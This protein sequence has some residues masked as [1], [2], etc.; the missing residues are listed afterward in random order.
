MLGLVWH[1]KWGCSRIIAIQVILL[2]LGMLGL[3]L[4]GLAVDFLRH[5]VTGGAAKPPRWPF[6]WTPPPDWS[7]MTTL[8][9]IALAILAFAATR[10]VL[11][12]LYTIAVNRLLQGEIVVQL[13]SRVYQKMQKLSF[14]FFDANASGAIINRV[15][16]D[17]QAVRSFVDGVTV[18]TLILLLS[19]TVYTVYMVNIDLR[20][21]LA[22]LATTPLMW[23][24]TA[25]FS[26]KVRPA[27]M[28]NRTLFDSLILALSENI[29]GVHVVKGFARQ[30]EEIDKFCDASN[31]V[32]SQKHWIFRQISFFQPLTGFLTQINL[33]VLLAY[34]GLLV[35]RHESAPD[36]ETAAAV[37]L[38]VG[39]L[40]VFAGLLQQFS[41]QVA[42]ITN[43]A[44]S[45]QQS[46]TGAERVFEI[47]DAP[48][49][50]RND[51]QPVRLKRSRGRV[52]FDQACFS[53]KPESPTLTDISFDV[54]PG[55]CVAVLGATGA[56]KSTL[57]SLVPRFYDVTSG[58]VSVDG[59][60][61][62]RILLDDLRQSI[63]VVFQESF[64]FSNTV[65]AN[66][67]FGSPDADDSL[68]E[69]AARIA[70]AHDFIMAMPDGYNTLLREGG[71]NLSG[72]QR[73]RIALARALLLDPAILMLD[74]PTAAIDPQTEADILQA[75][76]SAME[77]RT[78]FLVA[79]RLSTLR[80]ADL[81][82]VL[83]RG[84]IVQQGTHDE[85]MKLAG[86]YRHAARLQIPDAESMR[87]LGETPS[88][89]AQV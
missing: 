31:A 58:S 49:E 42:N 76:N 75:M 71:S 69:R 17:V 6:G 18:Q 19:L 30:K 66:I 83:D 3:G 41:G 60:D 13:R 32:R 12:M 34:G 5:H 43:I 7:P 1:Y 61:V 38:S 23:V 37:G 86:H 52:T 56:G 33:V 15:T 25:R 46:L 78:T 64:L 11:N 77:G 63:G 68:I 81:V 24:V 88:G 67:A 54:Q 55:Q 57:L 50:I 70:A 84:R 35:I 26:R 29:R 9:A 82:I 48:I 87:L 36:P 28:E 53:Y 65:K 79:H 89:G 21:T 10:S 16:G 59:T 47:L 74:D 44:D 80:R 20:L 39:Q 45:M 85:L 14:R 22:C 27:Y 72:G 62:R 2:S 40:L 8:G 51:S 4:T 73:Q